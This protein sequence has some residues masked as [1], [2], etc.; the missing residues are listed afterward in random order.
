M[1]PDDELFYGKQFA[2]AKKNFE[3]ELNTIEQEHISYFKS[4]PAK[5]PFE[6]HERLHNHFIFHYNGYHTTFGQAKGSDLPA[7]IWDQCTASFRK[8]FEPSN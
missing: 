7:V 6:E 1:I 8:H 3:A 2:N 5:Y 4:K